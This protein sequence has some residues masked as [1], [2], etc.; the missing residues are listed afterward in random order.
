M[1]QPDQSRPVIIIGGASRA[2]YALAEV[3]AAA[4]IVRIVRAPSGLVGERVVPAYDGVPGDLALDGATIINCAG[5]PL[6]D[7]AG[8]ARAN[9]DVPLAWARRAVQEGAARF[10]QISSFS[11]YGPTADITGDT[12]AN[13]ISDYGRSKLAAEQALERCGLGDRL[14]ILRVPI[15]VGGG[16]DKLA[17]LINLT[18]RTGIVPAS[19]NPA[20]RSML[21]YDGLAHTIAGLID[22]ARGGTLAAAD[23]EPFTPHLLADIAR[24]AGVPARIVTVPRFALAAVRRVAP[25]VHA[26]LFQPNL[27]DSAANAAPQH[28]PFERLRDVVARLLRIAPN[29]KG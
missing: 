20:P 21:S 6:G 26:S 1:S 18:R 8:L 3:M 5:T 14:T 10:V 24:Q 11:I 23:P 2:G 15:L 25:S 13:P 22:A 19:A 16:P 28:L 7:A 29:S 12:V 4:P 9:V 27:L 17:Q